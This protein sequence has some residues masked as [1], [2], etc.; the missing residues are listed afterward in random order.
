MEN[1]ALVCHYLGPKLGIGQYLDQLLPF[2]IKALQRQ[3]L[4]VR[5][6]TSP[7]ANKMTPALKH[8]SKFVD[9]LPPLDTSPLRRWL[10][11]AFRF[12]PYCQ[13]EKIKV[14]V[15]LS[16]PIVMPWHPPSIAVIHDVNEWKAQTKYGSRIRTLLRSFIYL[17][18]SLLFA[19]RLIAV[20]ELTG[21]DLK[22][23]RPSPKLRSKLTVI[24]NGMDTSLVHLPPANIS[25][26]D[27]PFL[28][29]VGRI[30]PFAKRLPESIQFTS[31]LREV[32][33]RAWEIHLVGGMNT[34]TQQAGEDFLES[35]KGI[36]WV[37][38]HG[39]V[40]DVSLAQWYRESTA[41]LFLSDREGFGLPVTEARSFRRWAIVSQNNLAAV[42][43]GGEGIIPIDPEQPRQGAVKALQIISSQENPPI[44][45]PPNSW[46]AAAS[47]YA[48]EISQVL[49]HS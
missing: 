27:A 1:V 28:L 13:K 34:S 42:E 30:D 39:H 25:A 29:C 4:N 44:D 23:F 36:S 26:P 5:L 45:C 47:Q 48:H 43:S 31:A 3:G 37:H 8:L 15:W 46:E 19:K 17:D 33:K 11:L 2:L 12:T 14:V 20:S 21:Q 6:I 10:W 9:I 35:V 41:V 38:Y 49:S 16:N 40:S 18:A 7:N 22:Q 24:V 32:S